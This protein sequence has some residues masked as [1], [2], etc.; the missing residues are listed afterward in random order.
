MAGP[1]G[2]CQK[3]QTGQSGHIHIGH[4]SK[5]QNLSQVH[6]HLDHRNEVI[7]NRLWKLVE[8]WNHPDRGGVAFSVWLPL[9]C[10][11]T[12]PSQKFCM[13]PSV[14][15]LHRQSLHP[16]LIAANRRSSVIGLLVFVAKMHFV[17]LFFIFHFIPEP[18]RRPCISSLPSENDLTKCTCGYW[19]RVFKE[20]HIRVMWPQVLVLKS[21]TPTR[22]T[23]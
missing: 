7:T 15:C 20:L 14:F 17:F 10:Y 21:Q 12:F 16:S 18:L 8:M 11:L 2:F 4:T 9:P 23:V 3:C 1:S 6:F 5:R 22:D 13:E 19:R